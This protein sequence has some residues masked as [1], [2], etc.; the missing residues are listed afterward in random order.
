M[1]VRTKIIICLNLVTQRLT[2]LIDFDS[3]RTNGFFSA[4]LF[5]AFRKFLNFPNKLRNEHK[6]FSGI[7]NNDA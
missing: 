2:K 3:A 7:K 1:Q 6:S 4:A 5:F